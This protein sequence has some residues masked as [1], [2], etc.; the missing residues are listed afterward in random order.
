MSICNVLKVLIA[1]DHLTSRMITVEGFRAMGIGNIIVAKDGREAYAKLLKSPVHLVVTDLYMPDINGYQ[2]LKA[3][4][5]HPKVNKTGVIIQ[6]GKKDE[7]VV[8]NAKTL[9]VNNVLA[10]PFTEFGLRQAVESVVGRL[11]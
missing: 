1:D 9:G 5:S 2:L 11:S 10:K 3:I 8:A 7:K 4:R 6:T